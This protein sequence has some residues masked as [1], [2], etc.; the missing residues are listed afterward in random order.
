MVDDKYFPLG[1]TDANLKFVRTTR[2]KVNEDYGS[3]SSG[4]EVTEQDGQLMVCVD[5]QELFLDYL[6]SDNNIHRIKIGVGQSIWNGANQEAY[7]QATNYGNEIFNN[8]INMA[9]TSTYE[10]WPMNTIG[11]VG[12]VS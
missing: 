8:Y 5:T 1:L 7:I 10:G 3:S 11:A 6:G 2:A 12:G 9:Y 4:A